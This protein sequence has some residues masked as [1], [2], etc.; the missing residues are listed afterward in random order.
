VLH[1]RGSKTVRMHVVKHLSGDVLSAEEEPAVESPALGL[2]QV[3]A[4]RTLT[5]EFSLE[6]GAV[7]KTGFRYRVLVRR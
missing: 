7:W 2:G 1:N 3:N 5:W 6:P 4:A